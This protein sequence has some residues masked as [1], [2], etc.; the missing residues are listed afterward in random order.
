[1]QFHPIKN[2]IV[3]AHFGANIPIFVYEYHEDTKTTINRDEV[4]MKKVQKKNDNNNKLDFNT[5]LSKID[6]IIKTQK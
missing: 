1:M 6:Q 2:I 4:D 3:F 5:I